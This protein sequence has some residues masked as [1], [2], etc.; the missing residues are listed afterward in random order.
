MTGCDNFKIC[1]YNCNG[2]NESKKR[3]DIFDFLRQKKADI[4]CL[5]ETHLTTKAENFIRASWGYNVWL[6]GSDT[7][8]NGV[9]I[10]FNNTFEY[11]II[12]V[13]RDDDGCYIVMNVELF[14]KRFTL[15]NLY[16]PSCGDKPDFFEHICRHI[17]DINNDHVIMTGDWN[18]ALN[19]NLDIRNY[20]STHHRPRTRKKLHD[21][22]AQYNLF[23]IFREMY[24][25]KRSY[26]WRKFNSIKQARLDYF[27]VS[28][29]VLTLTNDVTTIP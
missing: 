16:G 25:E 26:T 23:D 2:L 22:M 15:V 11:R 5:Q 21:I 29:E 18:C 6:S 4:Y 12:D 1:S 14:K 7:N 10:L 19:T 8:K 24:P 20:I 3:K 17:E 28:E 27:L 9:A 13:I